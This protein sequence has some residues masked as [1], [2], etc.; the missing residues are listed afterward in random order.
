MNTKLRSQ[1]S[2]KKHSFLF[3]TKVFSVLV[4]LVGGASYYHFSKL[5]VVLVDGGV[6]SQMYQ[7][8][9]GQHMKDLGY[10][11]KYDLRFF[12]KECRDCCNE[13]AREFQL[14][15]A[16]PYLKIP[17]A[18]W[19]ERHICGQSFSYKNKT[20]DHFD[21][22]KS[23]PP[24]YFGGYQYN[25]AL[26][27]SDAVTW[28]I[29]YE[30]APYEKYFHFEESTLNEKSRKVLH[31]IRR[32]PMSV[33]V[34]V[35]LGDYNGGRGKPIRPEY[36]RYF[37][38]AVEYMKRKFPQA[39]FFFFSEEPDLVRQ[40]IVSQISKD[41]VCEVMEANRSE[42]GYMDLFLC[43]ACKHQIMSIGSWRGPAHRLNPY[44]EKMLIVPE[45]LEALL[46]EEK[47]NR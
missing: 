27:T 35:R 10:N 24:V 43:S 34:H 15:K 8:I 23:S 2:Q 44:K 47:E 20:T 5:V 6:T 39:C 19:L 33:G 32:E 17:R 30:V 45:R 37:V 25:V 18:N 16:F 12:E 11:V 41:I 1:H 13:F 21:Y 29:R 7:Y 4:L 38:K 28:S 26:G 14:L 31:K 40:Y 46:Q 42:E 36:I 3:W 9:I 22:L